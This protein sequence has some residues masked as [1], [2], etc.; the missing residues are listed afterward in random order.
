MTYRHPLTQRSASTIV[1]VHFK[2]GPQPVLLLQ[3]PTGPV[4]P[5]SV[6]DLGA[7]VMI[8]GQIAS[9]LQVLA[10]HMPRLSVKR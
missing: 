5:G 8:E 4:D 7:D 3:G 10:L 1:T 6:L 2:A 9:N